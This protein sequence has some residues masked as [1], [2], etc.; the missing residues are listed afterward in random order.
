MELVKNLIEIKFDDI[1][2]KIDF[3]IELYQELQVENR[4]LSSKI[5]QLEE[6]LEARIDT[7]KKISEQDILAH[8]KIDSL[9]KKLD[10]FSNSVTKA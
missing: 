6:D 10:D 3:M 5:K 7:E 1:N 4:E 8:S 2:S 9:L